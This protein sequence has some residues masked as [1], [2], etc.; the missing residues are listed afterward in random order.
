M[1]N[2]LNN[3]KGITLIALVITIIV[4]LILAGVS[5][6]LISGSEGIL[7]KAT[8]AVDQTNIAGAK[9]ELEMAVLTVK[10]GY[11]TDNGG[12]SLSDYMKEH[13]NGYKTGNGTISCDE[14]GKV[15]YTANGVAVEGTVDSKGNFEMV[16]IEEKNKLTWEEIEKGKFKCSDGT[17]VNFGDYVAYDEGTA[18]AHNILD[19][20][21]GIGTDC[22]KAW[23]PDDGKLFADEDLAPQDLKWR[24]LGVN[25][26]GQLELISENPESAARD[27]PNARLIYLGYEAGY[28]NSSNNL[29]NYC[30]QLYG[31]GTYASSARSLNIEDVNNLITDGYDPKNDHIDNIGYGT[32]WRYCYDPLY[33]SIRYSNLADGFWADWQTASGA[34]IFRTPGDTDSQVIKSGQNEGEANARILENTCYTYNLADHM[35]ENV[36]KFIGSGTDVICSQF[37]ASPCVKCTSECA[38]FIVPI[39]YDGKLFDD[40]VLYNSSGYERSP[41]SADVR[42]VVTLSL[43]VKLTKEDFLEADLLDISHTVWALSPDS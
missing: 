40:L 34:N 15:T 22:G 7:G 32:K 21:K 2:L 29:N 6:N 26:N 42:P 36:A 38:E 5:L 35:A 16:N 28:L 25:K 33:S 39:L 43:N 10:M 4:L 20:N 17:V 30:N 31:K 23:T 19:P 13:L 24:V 11:Y 3:K 1:F 12:N 14:S 18:I 9:E 8:K 41:Y 27:V 37:L